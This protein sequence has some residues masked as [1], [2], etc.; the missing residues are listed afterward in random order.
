M[1]L[2][3]IGETSLEG[4]KVIQRSLRKDS[5]GQFVRAFCSEELSAAGWRTPVMQI[6][7]S[8]TNAVGSVRGLHYQKPPKAEKK[9]VL[10]LRGKVWDVAVDLRASSATFL[11]WYAE[12]LSEE[13]NKALLIPEGFAHGF[14]VL[15]K[16]SELLYL[17][18]EQ[19]APQLE[20]GISLLDPRLSIPWPLPIA[21]MSDRDRGFPL[22]TDKYKGIFL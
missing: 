2:F 12:E 21:E 4:L 3:H 18:S 10:C 5:R 22:L 9:M 6:N 17:H 16:E 19:Y 14:Q 13:N 11:S 7:Q 8:R 15:E 20:D 1:S